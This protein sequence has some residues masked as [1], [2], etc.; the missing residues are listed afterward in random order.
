M[1]YRLAGNRSL[2]IALV[3]TILITIVFL[4]IGSLWGITFLD[5]ISDPSE[6]RIAISSMSADQR[7]V[8]AWI[9]A[10]LDVVYPL[11]YGALF[12]GSA[13]KF[14]DNFG[15]LIASPFFVLVPTDLLEGFI[16]VL[17]LTGTLDMIDAKA[18]LTPLKTS[19]FLLGVSTMIIG[20]MLNR[21]GGRL[22]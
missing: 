11:A 13:L 15:W 16:Q 12:I 7:L 9:T 1:F 8:H 22:G 6:A 3:A 4:V 5:K 20:F 2:L 18:V 10:T 17:A 19:L 21:I 14:Y